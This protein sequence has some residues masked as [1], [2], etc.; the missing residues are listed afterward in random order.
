MSAFAAF[1]IYRN[2]RRQQSSKAVTLVI[3]VVIAILFAFGAVWTLLM[4]R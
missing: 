3:C 1:K 2:S 4:E